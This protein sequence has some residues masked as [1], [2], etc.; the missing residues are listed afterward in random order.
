M[1]LPTRVR[2]FARSWRCPVYE[3]RNRVFAVA[4]TRANRKFQS[5]EVQRLRLSLGRQ[6]QARVLVVIPTYK[7]PVG[8]VR[9]VG[10]ALSQSYRDLVVVVVDDGGG[11][12]DLPPDPRLVAVSL[13]RNSATLGLVRNVGINLADSEF[14][15]F[16]DDDNVWTP[17]HVATAVAALEGDPTLAAVYTSVRRLRPDGSEMDVLGEPFDRR[18]LRQDPYV[19]ANSIVVR[20]SSNLGFSVLPR[21]K[22]TLPKEDW[23]YVWRMSRRGRVA[24]VPKV[25]VLYS[26]NPDSYYTTWDDG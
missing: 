18:K 22:D 9:A 4:A 6:A 21:N 26:V 11:L 8:L 16:L 10:S 19:D 5:D 2:R 3:T 13:S 12:P 23:E 17:D 20:R 1:R 15:G 24:H 14:I 7:R 25:T